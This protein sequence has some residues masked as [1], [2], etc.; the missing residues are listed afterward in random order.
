MA[1]GCHRIPFWPEQALI[2]LTDYLIYFLFFS[3]YH[4]SLAG[5]VARFL[6][7]IIWDFSPSDTNINSSWLQ[8]S[9]VLPS[10]GKYWRKMSRRLPIKP[11]SIAGSELGCMMEYLSPTP[12]ASLSN[13]VRLSCCSDSS[14]VSRRAVSM[15][16]TSGSCVLSCGSA[17]CTGRNTDGLVGMER[18]R[19]FDTIIFICYARSSVVKAFP[20]LYQCVL[21]SSQPKPITLILIFS[22]RDSSLDGLLFRFSVSLSTAA[23]VLQHVA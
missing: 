3:A 20:L 14:L 11:L 1:T 5:L 15:A 7:L 8:G 17:F 9:S 16:T 12:T 22:F 21:R 18:Y 10:S 13:L 23:A 6:T 19:C 2:Q 4:D